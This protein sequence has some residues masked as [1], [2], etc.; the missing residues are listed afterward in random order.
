MPGGRGGVG[1][2][3]LG[4]GAQ[5]AAGC[6]LRHG[7]SGAAHLNLSSWLVVASA[8]A[9]I[10][11]ARAIQRRLAVT[12]GDVVPVGLGFRGSPG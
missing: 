11:T 10:G 1:G 4:V 5:L 6:N 12:S 3:L 2:A 9:G 8:V 7:M